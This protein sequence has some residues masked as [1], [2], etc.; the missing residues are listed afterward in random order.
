[1][2]VIYCQNDAGT[3]KARQ[4][5]LSLLVSQLQDVRC[6]SLPQ[7]TPEVAVLDLLAHDA[8]AQQSSLCICHST[9]CVSLQF[10]VIITNVTIIIVIVITDI[11]IIIVGVE[12][13][14]RVGC[15]L[16]RLACLGVYLWTW[17]GAWPPAAS[18]RQ[19]LAR[20]DPPKSS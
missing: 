13:G 17:W 14:Q 3:S 1:M 19:P 4:H 11:T 2:H 9:R 6:G 20:C 18:P 12:E 16:D 15:L 7:V 8:C 10:I 5:E